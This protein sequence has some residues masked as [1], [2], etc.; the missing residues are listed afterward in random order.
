M[1][2]SHEEGNYTTLSSFTFEDSNGNETAYLS[3]WHIHAP[4]DHSVQGDRSK[5]ELHFV[6]VD[7][8]GHT[9]AVLAFRIDPG[10]ANSS[11]FAQL[12]E[13]VSYRNTTE[14]V[15]ATMNPSLALDEVNHFNEFWT[16]KGSLTSPPC[17]EGIRWYL[18]RN[19]LFV[20]NEQMQALL[21]VSHYSARAEQE[22][23]LHQINV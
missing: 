4:A 12:P 8:E 7:A 11:F 3:G 13:L 9:R 14:R 15:N 22:A 10:N 19:I 1:T 17:T 23:W 20:S 5:A 18:A 2:Y 21:R 6:H 16:Y